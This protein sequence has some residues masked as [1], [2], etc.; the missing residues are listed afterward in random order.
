MSDAGSS[1]PICLRATLTIVPSRKTAPDP[2][3]VATRVQRWRVVMSGQ[4]RSARRGLA[5]TRDARAALDSPPCPD[6]W[7]SSAPVNSSLRWPDSTRSCWR[8]PA[9]RG[10]R[11]AILPT[12]SYPD[13]EDVFHRW[14]AMG[15]AHFGQLGAEVEPVLVRDRD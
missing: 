11:V 13:G 8:R 4:C 7:R 2:M 14:A 5:V 1:C 12:A 3:I 15:V 9:A 6:P 10:P